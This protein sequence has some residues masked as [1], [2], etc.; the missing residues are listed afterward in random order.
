M[1]SSRSATAFSFSAVDMNVTS[2]VRTGSVWA[3]QPLGLQ[4]RLDRDGIETHRR[5]HRRAD[6]DAPQILALRR[7]RLE[8]HDFAQEHFD[9]LEELIL[10]ERRL[11]H[12]GVQISGLVHAV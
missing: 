8:A 1:I 3:L 10:P 7:R 11:A 9:V 4:A 12:R 6:G 5:S 2:S